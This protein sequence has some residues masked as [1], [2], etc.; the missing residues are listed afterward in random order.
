MYIGLKNIQ[1]LFSDLPS[2]LTASDGIH[3][4]TGWTKLES[5]PH[6]Y[7][8]H[9]LYT[10]IY[11]NELDTDAFAGEIE[12]HLLCIASP[13]ADLAAAARRFPD[14]VSLLMLES[15]RPEPVYTIL[16]HYFNM[17]CGIGMFGQTLL[18]YLSFDSGL[19]SAI[20]HSYGALRNPVFVF[21]TNYNLIAATW[22]AIEK[23]EINDPVILKKQFS[24]KEFK[25]VSRENNLHS[26]VRRSEL[27]IRSYNAELGYEQMYCAI[28][29]KKDLGHIVISAVNKP[30]EPIDTEFLLT[31]KKYV[32]QQME[33]DSFIRHSRGFNYEY[34]LKDLLDKKI[35]VDSSGMSQ[36]NYI[37]SEFSGNMYCIVVETARSLYTISTT[38]IRN[39]LESHFPYSKTLIYNGQVIAIP[40]LQKGLLISQEYIDMGKKLC[41]ENGLFA[42]LSNCFTDIMN[43]AEYYN[44]AL[45]AIELGGSQDNSPNLF[46]YE[47]Y[48]LDHVKNIFTQKESAETFCH[49]KMK[50]LLD[51]DKKHNSELAY[52]LYMYLTHERNLAST[53]EAMQMHRSSLVY[54][55]KKIDSLLKDDFEDYKER[56]YLILSYEMHQRKEED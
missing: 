26:K 32:N 53:A 9:L 11:D 15:D 28:N 52:T 1:N 51:Y 47:D 18:E 43:F 29:T 21:D 37:K 45:R 35:A 25:M 2:L 22:K 50:F 16:Q 8:N 39:M 42:G 14:T 31:L 23:L 41:R 12:I 19:Q 3:C 55:F 6:P 36:L 49:P 27:P 30:F 54:R 4:L 48:Y 46:L 17:Q 20:E 40:S 13:G 38:H 34:F 10:C 24:D 56:M 44:Q 7:T 5:A 33:K